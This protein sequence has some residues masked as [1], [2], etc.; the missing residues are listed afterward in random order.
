MS[1]GSDSPMTELSV[2]IMQTNIDKDEKTGDDFS[3]HWVN[4]TYF[5]ELSCLAF[6]AISEQMVEADSNPKQRKC[7][8]MMVKLMKIVDDAMVSGPQTVRYEPIGP[9][10]RPESHFISDGLFTDQE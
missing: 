1:D 7:R 9:I 5:Q 10:K 3:C 2:D 4:A 6:E 8:G